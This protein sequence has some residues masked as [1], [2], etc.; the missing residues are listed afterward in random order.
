MKSESKIWA[1]P[2]DKM[3]LRIIQGFQE[4]GH[5]IEAKNINP[6]LAQQEPIVWWALAHQI[7]D[8]DGWTDPTWSSWELRIRTK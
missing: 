2:H 6:E 3:R 1:P 5:E 7:V 8:Y 4:Q